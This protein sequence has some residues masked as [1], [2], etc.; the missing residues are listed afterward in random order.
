MAS[1]LRRVVVAALLAAWTF[2]AASALAEPQAAPIVSEAQTSS[3]AARGQVA[4]SSEAAGYAAREQQSPAN[5]NF[6]GGAF[7][8]IGGSVLA[9]ALVVLLILV[10][11]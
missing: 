5:Q 1:I 11:V 2:P 6:Q 10:L 9:A 7:I 8:Y 4:P 3:V